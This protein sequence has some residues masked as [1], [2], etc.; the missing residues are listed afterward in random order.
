MA[1]DGPSS[2]IPENF[3]DNL[4]KFL[5]FLSTVVMESDYTTI[6]RFFSPSFP[7]LG[8]AS[9][10]PWQQPRFPLLVKRECENVLAPTIGLAV[11]ESWGRSTGYDDE[12]NHSLMIARDSL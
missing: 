8:Q 9:L 4:M 1:A 3:L 2:S 7:R 5:Y 10:P 12:Q 6:P 11:D